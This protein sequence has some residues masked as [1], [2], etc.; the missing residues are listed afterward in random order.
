MARADGRRLIRTDAAGRGPASEGQTGIAASKA[1]PHR[2][3][4]AGGKCRIYAI[5]NLSTPSQRDGP[6]R[7]RAALQPA[8][9]PPPRSAPH[10]RRHSPCADPAAAAKRSAQERILSN[11]GPLFQSGMEDLKHRHFP[12]ASAVSSASEATPHTAAKRAEKAA[13]KRPIQ[14]PSTPSQRDG[15]RPAGR[16]RRNQHSRRPPRSA[17]PHRHTVPR[18]HAFSKVLANRSVPSR[19]RRAPARSCRA[20]RKILK[21]RYFPRTAVYYDRGK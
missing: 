1:A 12:H 5:L 19:A 18:L 14:N 4:E 9:T 20:G 17:P 8:S 10:P 13:T 15:P 16:Q 3:R 11:A 7:S 21:H 6:L 2:R